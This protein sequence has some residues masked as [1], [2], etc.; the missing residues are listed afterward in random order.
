[1]NGGG[2]RISPDDIMLGDLIRTSIYLK[3][4]VEY[5]VD[6][7]IVTG[8]SIYRSYYLIIYFPDTGV[9]GATV[10]YHTGCIYALR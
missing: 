3:Y 1:M 4:S 9:Y 6:G 10:D 8:I 5:K 2:A 7:D